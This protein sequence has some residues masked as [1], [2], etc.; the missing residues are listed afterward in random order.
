MSRRAFRLLV[1]GL[2]VVAAL[3][4]ACGTPTTPTDTVTAPASPTAGL[5]PVTETFSGTLVSGGAN[6]HTFHTMQGS[7]KLT[8]ALVSPPDASLIRMG[9]GM[10]DGLSCQLVFQSAPDA[11]ATDLTATASIET[12]VCVK[13]WDEGSLAADA[14]LKYQ[15]TAVHN[16]KPPS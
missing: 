11:T 12:Q 16:E 5:V 13:V 4:L 9:I 3:A 1:L 7:V 8:L 6:F 14:A 15:V 10:W 2:P